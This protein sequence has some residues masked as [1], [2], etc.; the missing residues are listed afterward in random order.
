MRKTIA[1]IATAFAALLFVLNWIGYVETIRDVLQHRGVLVSAAVTIFT[2]QWFALCIFVLGVFALALIQWGIPEWIKKPAPITIILSPRWGYPTFAT[3][4]NNDRD[5]PAHVKRSTLYGI[6]KRGHKEGLYEA[7]KIG[8]ALEAPFTIDPQ[9]RVEQAYGGYISFE[10]FKFLQ[11]EIEL[12]NGKLFLSK[13]VKSPTPP[14]DKTK[15][16]ISVPQESELRLHIECDSSVE[17]CVAEARWTINGKPLRVNFFR[18]A[19]NVVG[20]DQSVRNC[21]GFLRRIEKN[22]KTKWGGN[23]AQLTFAQAEEPD[24]FSKV[25]RHSVA[26]YLD[27]L[28]VTSGN[29]IF[30]GTK[31][32]SGIR[33]WP[34][35]PGMGEI[36]SEPGD[37]LL[38]VV[39]TGDGVPPITAL[40]KFT[41]TQDWQ[42]AALTLIPQSAGQ[43]QRQENSLAARN[44]CDRIADT[45]GRRL[46]EIEKGITGNLDNIGL[47]ESLNIEPEV[48]KQI[49]DAPKP[50]EGV[51]PQLIE[52][53]Y[54]IDR[55]VAWPVFREMGIAIKQLNEGLN[56]NNDLLSSA[57]SRELLEQI[58]GIR[59]LIARIEAE[60]TSHGES[61]QLKERRQKLKNLLAKGQRLDAMRE[62]VGFDIAEARRRNEKF[63]AEVRADINRLENEQS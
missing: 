2:S 56:K 54:S 21:T 27:V 51:E 57:L 15:L 36:F 26:E 33:G 48:S 45:I 19:V 16:P 29:Q 9:R 12:E 23:N 30:P 34:F 40:L 31:P 58:E 46:T 44:K 59:K 13:K 18:I 32:I 14:G 3:V 47:L 53:A 5:Y 4:I 55:D 41:W 10:T 61:P 6:K 50:I 43:A 17:G 62:S 7:S 49:Q 38:T 52:E 22:G 37:Y 8:P 11:A 42:T 35:V 63:I 60:K 1:W 24:T 39:I 20:Q 25:I 28:A